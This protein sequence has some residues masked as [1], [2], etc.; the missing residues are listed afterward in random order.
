M[1]NKTLLK[2][3]PHDNLYT[4]RKGFREDAEP[5]VFRLAEIHPLV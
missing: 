5:L 2:G 3:K 4:N 1:A